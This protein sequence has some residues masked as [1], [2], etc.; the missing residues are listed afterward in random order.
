MKGERL[1]VDALGAYF[2]G[3]A[4]VFAN[5][6]RLKLH[7]T[8]R[9]S[10]TTESGAVGWNLRG[11]NEKVPLSFHG[12]ELVRRD[13]VDGKGGDIG[14]GVGDLD[15]G[16]KES[17]AQSV[18]MTRVAVGESAALELTRP[19]Q[20]QVAGVGRNRRGFRGALG[21][22]GSEATIPHCDR[23][24]ACGEYLL[25]RHAAP[26]LAGTRFDLSQASTSERSKRNRAPTRI[27]G[28]GQS[29]R[30]CRRLSW[31]SR[32][33]AQPR[34]RSSIRS[35]C[36]SFDGHVRRPARVRG[37]FVDD[38][39]ERLL[40]PGRP[41]TRCARRQCRCDGLPRIGLARNDHP[42]PCRRTA[43]FPACP[44]RGGVGARG[45]DCHVVVSLRFLVVLFVFILAI[46]VFVE[47]LVLL[48]VVSFEEVGFVLVIVLVGLR[49]GA[50]PRV[51]SSF[52]GQVRYGF[53]EVSTHFGN[54]PCG[55]RCR[56]WAALQRK[57]SSRP[58]PVPEVQAPS[59]SNSRDLPGG[60]RHRQYFPKASSLDLR[61][62][63]D[64]AYVHP[65]RWESISSFLAASSGKRRP[66]FSASGSGTCNCR[67]LRPFR[68]PHL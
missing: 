8:R 12:A 48:L 51:K 31:R 16:R 9:S 55:N 40:V 37:L 6:S 58:C 38:V 26:L 56:D 59:S 66:A 10:G 62:Q 2:D 47:V 23:L 1:D 67:S 27:A 3:P 42:V 13:D 18:R 32:A 21:V 17:P 68:Q 52:T 14:G 5:T 65:A 43:A 63:L 35:S 34:G 54:T 64:R 60:N 19:E 46:V 29:E 61:A 25:A 36:P 33:S 28:S 49:S 7:G 39:D 11:G 53:Q 22:P 41:G 44:R 30:D 50:G 57:H 4:K 45:T 20:F 24:I 15:T